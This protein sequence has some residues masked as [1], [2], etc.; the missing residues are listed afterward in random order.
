MVGRIYGA[1]RGEPRSVRAGRWS[2]G[3]GVEADHDAARRVATVF[4]NL[5]C[6]I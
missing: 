5:N 3:N 6:L 2:M 4:E 1:G